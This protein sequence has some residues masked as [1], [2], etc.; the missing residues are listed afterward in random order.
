MFQVA[1]FEGIYSLLWFVSEVSLLI[2]GLVIKTVLL[3]RSPVDRSAGIF[4]LP[5]AGS[6]VLLRKEGNG[7]FA[8]RLTSSR[9]WH[10]DH[11]M[12]MCSMCCRWGVATKPTC[13]DMPKS[14]Q[15]VFKS[16]VE[17]RTNQGILH[18]S[19]DRGGLEHLFD[20]KM[21]PLA[22]PWNAKLT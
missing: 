8:G 22:R 3:A 12:V 14:T 9:K 17:K 11:R 10:W 15:L 21:T 4:F 6:Q 20:V 13:R 5:P 16:R 1:I 7:T 19:W 2:C 18:E